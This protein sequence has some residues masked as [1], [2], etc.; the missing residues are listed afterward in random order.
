MINGN[1]A[2]DEM[3]VGQPK[4]QD[5]A[6]LAEL[7]DGTDVAMLTTRAADGSLVSRPIQT[8][9]F[10]GEGNIYFF[11]AADSAKVS[12]MTADPEVN[13]AY[14]NSASHRYVS[15][16]GHATISRDRAKIE[17]LWSFIQKPFFPEGKDDPNLV[18]LH[19][20]VRD[21]AY[22]E[23]SGNVLVR[24]INFATAIMSNEPSDLG[25]QGHLTGRA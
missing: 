1:D 3:E 2:I 14:A 25:E 12:E 16:R 15:I 17:E 19:V 22:W 5:L 13:L 6:K 23:A 11:T 18:V 8:L 10:D 21:A 9:Q 4:T 20:K 24:A 7:L